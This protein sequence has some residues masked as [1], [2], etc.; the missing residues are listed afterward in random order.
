MEGLREGRGT[1]IYKEIFICSGLH[2]GRSTWFC[3]EIRTI[4]HVLGAKTPTR[5][6]SHLESNSPEFNWRYVLVG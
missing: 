2:K 5:T 1:G 3:N 4:F 6:P